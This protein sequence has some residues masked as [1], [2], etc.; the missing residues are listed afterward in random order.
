MARAA[1]ERRVKEHRLWTW[2]PSTKREAFELEAKALEQWFDAGGQC[3]ARE[4]DVHRLMYCDG[5]G[6]RAA[7]KA[8]GISRDSVR[9]YR[10]RLLGRL[11]K[12]ND[13]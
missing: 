3:P 13:E 1:A 8:L 5:L 9:M 6:T 2:R 4:L 10:K 7:A 12:D 11:S